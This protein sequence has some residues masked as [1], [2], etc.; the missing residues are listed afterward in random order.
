MLDPGQDLP[1]GRAI[2]PE[3]IGHDHTGHVL[4]PLQQLLEEA[5]GRLRTAPAL[6]QD[7]EHGAVLI[8]RPP[9]IVLLR[10]A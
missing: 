7:V 4:Q 6:H 1:L 3:L 2:A 8:D 10:Q 9:Q 5:P